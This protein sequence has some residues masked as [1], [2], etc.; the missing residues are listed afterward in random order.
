MPCACGEELLIDH[1]IKTGKCL[2]CMMLE[3]QEELEREEIEEARQ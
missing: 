1:E 2:V 3:F